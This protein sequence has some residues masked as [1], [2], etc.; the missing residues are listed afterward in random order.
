MNREEGD[1]S[2]SALTRVS[3]GKE[4]YQKALEVKRILGPIPTSEPKAGGIE[5]S[6]GSK[7]AQRYGWAWS[8]VGE[9]TVSIFVS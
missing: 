7:R 6:C 1:H 9:E 8:G 5:A 2:C 4:R 3:K